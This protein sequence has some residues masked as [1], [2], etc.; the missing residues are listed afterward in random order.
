VK[1][2]CESGTTWLAWLFIA[3][4]VGLGSGCAEAEQGPHCRAY[5]DCVRQADAQ[6]G[7]VTNV[8]RFL[9]DGACW[10]GVKGAAVCESSCRRGIPVL[11]KQEPAIACEAAP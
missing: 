4:L 1:R 6:R 5:V 9:A 8:D 2:C 3:A 11:Q 7:S 10:D